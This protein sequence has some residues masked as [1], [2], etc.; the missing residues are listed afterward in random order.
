MGEP[1]SG[2]MRRDI[3][4]H[5]DGSADRQALSVSNS[6][7]GGDRELN[8]VLQWET[9]HTS[10]RSARATVLPSANVSGVWPSKEAWQ[11]HLSVSNSSLG[12]DR[13]LHKVPAVGDPT[14]LV[15]IG[16]NHPTSTGERQRRV[17][18]QGGMAACRVVVGLELTKLPLQITAIP[19]QHMVNEV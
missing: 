5:P 13:K 19:E 4:P 10:F 6:I 9:Q 2:V 17:A 18:V 11:E 14:H 7:S 8:E 12:G 1:A 15:Q 16:G 3:V